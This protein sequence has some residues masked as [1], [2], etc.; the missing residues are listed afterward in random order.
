MQSAD[1]A[2]FLLPALPDAWPTGNISGLRARGG[3]DIL[4][5][6]WKDGKLTRAV[7]RSRLGGNLR[8]RTPNTLQAANGAVLHP[9]SG[10]NSNPFYHIEEKP[11]PIISSDAKL[12]PAKPKQ[13]M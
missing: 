4:S 9:A 1:G 11:A 2:L 10:A 12:T 8:L 13:I 6:E 5:M 3:F 7:I